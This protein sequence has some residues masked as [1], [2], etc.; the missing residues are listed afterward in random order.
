MIFG[1]MVTAYIPSSDAK[2]DYVIGGD[3]DSYGDSK[4][5]TKAKIALAAAVLVLGPA[6][7]VLANDTAGE[8]TGGGPTQSWQDIQQDQQNIQRQIQN[9]YRTGNAGSDFGSAASPKHR[10]SHER[11]QD[12]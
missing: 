5:L 12:R 6:S 8:E 1:Q 9:Q 2:K 3:E 4:M 11:T 10:V 7:A